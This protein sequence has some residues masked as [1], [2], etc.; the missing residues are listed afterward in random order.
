MW[1]D[2]LGSPRFDANWCRRV[3][4]SVNFMRIVDGIEMSGCAKM[5]GMTPV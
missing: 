1:S 4:V 3:P 5:I 2:A